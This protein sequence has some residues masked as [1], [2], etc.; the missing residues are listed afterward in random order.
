MANT[1][2]RYILLIIAQNAKRNSVMQSFFLFVTYV[3]TMKLLIKLHWLYAD[4][5]SNKTST[6]RVHS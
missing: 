3:D 2:C 4:S 6:Q 1:I 5:G